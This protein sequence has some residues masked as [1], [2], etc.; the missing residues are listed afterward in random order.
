[1]RVYIDSNLGHHISSGCE[2]LCE[3]CSDYIR[4]VSDETE[5]VY[6]DDP[7]WTLVFW[8]ERNYH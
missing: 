7:N 8:N 2:E 4:V 3:T 6:R 5:D 1:M